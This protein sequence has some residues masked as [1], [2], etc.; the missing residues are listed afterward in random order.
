MQALLT[1]RPLTAQD[2]M[3]FMSKKFD[4]TTMTR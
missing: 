1:S 2:D 3:A 4:C